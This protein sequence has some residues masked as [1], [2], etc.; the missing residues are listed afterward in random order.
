MFNW[1]NRA[2]RAEKCMLFG[3]EDRQLGDDAYCGKC[4]Q[5]NEWFVPSEESPFGSFIKATEVASAMMQA[6]A[7]AFEQI[8]VS[9][10][11][12]VASMYGG[13]NSGY[14]VDTILAAQ[15]HL[16]GKVEGPTEE[17]VEP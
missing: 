9:M 3:H 12:P 10:L 11:L 7:N 8:A 17:S 15:E 4:G 1:I 16:R 14:T 13:I 5:R 6:L 2:R